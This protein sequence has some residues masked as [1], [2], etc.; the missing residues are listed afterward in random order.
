[1]LCGSLV[2]AR[3]QVVTIQLLDRS[4]SSSPS[5]A[6]S[7]FQLLNSSTPA[8]SSSTAWKFS[9]SSAPAAIMMPRSTAADKMPYVSTWAHHRKATSKAA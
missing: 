2:G 4:S 3:L 6:A 8:N 5:P 9:R 1:M 7:S